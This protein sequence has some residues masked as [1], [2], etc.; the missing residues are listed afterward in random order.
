MFW[1][2]RTIMH[3]IMHRHIGRLINRHIHRL[4][5][6][7]THL[8]THGHIHRLIHRLMH[9]LMHRLIHRLM[10]IRIRRSST[11]GGG[12]AWEKVC[13][14]A[15]DQSDIIGGIPAAVSH[16]PT[17]SYFGTDSKKPRLMWAE[18]IEYVNKIFHLL[19][20]A[21]Y[22][23]KIDNNY[24]ITANNTHTRHVKH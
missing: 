16:G 2:R 5:H 17:T 4:M 15:Y 14:S 12:G 22:F 10:H 13:H 24:I 3:R 23:W 8:V 18:T 19:M 21:K 6:S 1:S 11:T 7:L 20:N 9:R